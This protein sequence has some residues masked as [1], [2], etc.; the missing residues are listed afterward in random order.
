[1]TFSA[2][3]PFTFLSLSRYSNII[4]L[5]PIQFFQGVTALR[6]RQT[7]DDVWQQFSWQDG[8][9]ISREELRQAIRQAEDDLITQVS[10]F[11]TPYWHTETVDYPQFY[12]KEYRGISG[13]QAGGFLNKTVRTKRKHFIAG[14]TR[15]TT[16]IDA[17]DIT[18]SADI[19]TTGDGF[20]DTAVFTITNIDFTNIC[21]LHAYFKVYNVAD[22]ANTRT[23]P[24]SVGA[25]PY[26]EIREIRPVLSGTTATVYIPVYLLFRPQLQR[27]IDA[28]TIDADVPGSF[29]DTISF[30]RIYNDP[31]QQVTFLWAN[32]TSCNSTACA[33][34]T[35]TGC[36][37]HKNKRTGQVTVQPATYNATTGTYASAAF[38]QNIEPNRVALYYYSGFQ[39][40][41]ARNCDELSYWWAWN[42]AVLASARLNKDVC[43]CSNVQ[44][45]L[46]SWRED[47]AL[48][49]IVRSYNINPADLSNPFGTRLGEIQVWNRIK[50]RGIKVGQNINMY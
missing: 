43:S 48:I 3:F 47:M 46:N 24:G 39:D 40:Q 45:R 12:Q 18:R 19:D 4:G 41:T 29:V 32:E 1:M 33:W 17:S 34:A 16:A 20:D 38:N 14:G 6:S 11:P 37:R 9:K 31:S 8:G 15:A 21:E 5:D 23:D 7:C 28:T 2:E 27:Q 22:V 42:I 30:W 44:T 25:D 13:R 36:M 35:Q 10:Y 49:N 50:N 26:W